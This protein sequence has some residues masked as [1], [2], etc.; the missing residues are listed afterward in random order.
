MAPSQGSPSD[1]SPQ[2]RLKRPG[3][4]EILA[5]VQAL[6][7]VQV[8]EVE[9]LLLMKLVLLQVASPSHVISKDPL[10]P[11]TDK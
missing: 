2:V 1:A 5:P 6:D 3:P 4:E 10:P 11:E 8:N 9:L 7:W